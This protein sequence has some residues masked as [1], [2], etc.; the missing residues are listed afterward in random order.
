MFQRKH[1]PERQ[2]HMGDQKEGPHWND[3]I[4]NPNYYFGSGKAYKFENK[5]FR[6][7]LQVA[8]I[9]MAYDIV[10]DEYTSTN[11]LTMSRRTSLWRK[12]LAWVQN[13]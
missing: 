4:L 8:N 10:P 12:L 2:K 3:S 5:L 6:Q 13:H 7:K 11:F 9:M 1:F